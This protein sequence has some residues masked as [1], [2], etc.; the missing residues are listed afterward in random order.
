MYNLEPVP[1]FQTFA[2]V[3]N[4]LERQFYLID[5]AFRALRTTALMLDA[6]DTEP[7][8]RFDGLLVHALGS[9][10]NPGSGR[11]AYMY[12]ASAWHYLG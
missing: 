10:W 4:Y 6:I 5:N 2:E 12:Y 7:A 9:N 11:G 3:K 8:K 1:N